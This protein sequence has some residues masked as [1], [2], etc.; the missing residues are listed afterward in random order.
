MSVLYYSGQMKE[1]AAFDEEVPKADP[2]PEEL[3][4]ARTLIQ[5]SAID[6]FDLTRYKDTYAVKVTELIEAKVRGQEIVAP[7]PAEHPKVINLMDALKESLA[8]AR[9]K[10]PEAKEAPKKK[11]APSARGE[12]AARRKRKSS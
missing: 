2:S 10:A 1:P 3:K 8:E 4:L 9:R 7:P 12:A 11:M 6:D 5:A